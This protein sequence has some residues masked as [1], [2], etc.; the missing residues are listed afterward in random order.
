M[1]RRT[2]RGDLLQK[3][4]LVRIFSV[5]NKISTRHRIYAPR[6]RWLSDSDI[7]KALEQ[8]AEKI[9][10][11]LPGQEYTLVQVAPTRFNFVWRG[12]KECP[13]SK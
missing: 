4:I 6:G 10:K 2:S 13:S 7:D 9:E 12:T 1:Q 11:Q 3:E 8:I 5:E